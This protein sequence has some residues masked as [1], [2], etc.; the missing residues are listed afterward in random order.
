MRS[1]S[2]NYFRIFR[3]KCFWFS[4]VIASLIFSVYF[5]VSRAVDQLMCGV[6]DEWALSW[7]LHEKKIIWINQFRVFTLFMLQSRLYWYR[8]VLMAMKKVQMLIGWNGWRTSRQ[9]NCNNSSTNKNQPVNQIQIKEIPTHW[10]SALIMIKLFLT[11]VIYMKPFIRNEQ[12]QLSHQ[13]QLAVI[14]RN[15]MKPTINIP[16]KRTANMISGRQNSHFYQIRFK[17]MQKNSIDFHIVW[18]FATE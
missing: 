14:Y 4:T 12:R 17:I 9:C 13:W 8:I 16:V 1:V 10:K 6:T 5:I 15:R 18:T 2:P 11:A 7:R 3:L